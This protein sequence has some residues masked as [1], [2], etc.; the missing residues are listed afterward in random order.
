[1]TTFGWTIFGVG[2]L[3]LVGIGTGTY[4]LL[5]QPKPA[6]VE[7]A[8]PIEVPVV[9]EEVAPVATSTDTL[10]DGTASTTP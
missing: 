8:T 3:I 7:E 9:T 2:L 10:P 6:P 5:S 1:M 4:L